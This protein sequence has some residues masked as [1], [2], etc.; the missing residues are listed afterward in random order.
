[1]ISQARTRAT[2]P[3]VSCQVK[4]LLVS[5]ATDLKEIPSNSFDVVSASFLFCVLPNELQVQPTIM[6][7]HTSHNRNQYYDCLLLIVL[8]MPLCTI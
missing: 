3:E 8:S 4:A 6:Q 7:L 2:Q 5:D 1:M